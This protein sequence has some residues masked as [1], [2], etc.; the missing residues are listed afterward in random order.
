MATEPS[1]L[2]LEEYRALRATIRER[3]T[4]RL[5]VATITFVA[6]AAGALAVAAWASVAALALIPLLI[7]A[8]GFEVVFAAHVGVERVG[9]YLQTHFETPGAAPP[10]WERLAMEL[11]PQAGAGSGIDPLFSI[12]FVLA[13]LLNMLPAALLSLAGGPELPGGLSLELLVY[14]MLHAFF[15][16]RVFRARRFAA[17]QRLREFQ[18]FRDAGSPK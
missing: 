15:I 6:W 10:Q 18:L 14:G 17:R 9:R 4:I 2:A 11:G 8:A 1:P 3:G 12:L 5:I 16:G 7:L 13:A